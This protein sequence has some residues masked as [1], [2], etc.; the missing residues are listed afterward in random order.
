MHLTLKHFT[1]IL[2]SVLA[3][4][5]PGCS[6]TPSKQSD[7]P[8]SS[9]Y[10]DDADDYEEEPE[11]YEDDAEDD[12]YDDDYVEDD[13]EEEEED[14]Y[15]CNYSDGYHLATVDYYNPETEYS[16]TYDLNV[17]VEGCEVTKIVFPRG[18][19]LDD[20]H[21]IPADLDAWGTCTIY[22]EEGKIYEIQIN[23]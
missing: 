22:G 23:D 15:A 7:N 12:D 14:P 19:W 11:S 10:G 18:G 13:N 5:L 9:S 3:L 20:D 21:I 1:L 4:L 17:D 2:F 8:S 6:T 16:A